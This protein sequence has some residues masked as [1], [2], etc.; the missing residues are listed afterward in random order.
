VM[1]PTPTLDLLATPTVTLEAKNSSTLMPASALAGTQTTTTPTPGKVVD[2]CIKGQ[3]EWTFPKGGDEIN[4]TI[5]L[6][7]IVNVA[8]LGFYKYEYSQP[9]SSAW[10]TIAA[11]DKPKNDEPLGGV[12]NTSQ[13]VP[14]DYLLRLV[15]SDNKNQVL[16]A[17]QI[18]VQIVAQ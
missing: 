13:L 14:G 6:K 3:L 17:C 11:G 2:G 7:G 15:V 1:I 8:N 4:G 18:S 16:P 12:W 5:E 10:I 9:G